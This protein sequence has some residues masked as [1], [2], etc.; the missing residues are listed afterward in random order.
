VRRR[1][2]WD[3]DTTRASAARTFDEYAEAFRDRF[4]TAVRRRARSA[5]PVGVSVSGGLDSSA[6]FCQ[7]DALR[8]ADP[9]LF[10]E[11]VG[12]SYVD[13]GGAA[14][15]RHYLEIVE[16]A[17]RQSIV[18]LP[19]GDH[20]GLVDTAR[21]QLWHVETPS[22]DYLWRATVA[23][24]QALRT[25]GARVL[26][27]GH[28]GDQML[29]STGYLVDLAR[30]LSW[31]QLG[32][33]LV[34]YRR[35]LGAGEAAVYARRLLPEIARS[36]VPA[37]LRA[38]LKRLR[39]RWL[40][41]APRGWYADTFVDRARRGADAL[42]ALDRRCHSEQARRLYLEARSAY[43]V[44]CMEWNNKA[45]AMDGQD[46]AFPFLDRDLVSLLIAMPGTMQNH[47]GVPRA[48]LREAMRGVLPDAVRAR[49]W[50]ADFSDAVNAG[51]GREHATIASLLTRDAH[52]VRRGFF[53]AD[54][55]EP[56]VARVAAAGIGDDCRDSWD[57]ADAFGFELWLRVFF[58]QHEPPGQA[59]PRADHRVA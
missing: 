33:H 8:R 51:V 57:L 31:I 43:H 19:L 32:R 46:H 44:Q 59:G 45:A 13:V 6:I 3:F 50:K 18:R 23:I 5:F 29:F 34:E 15:E 49:T 24:G 41:R 21:S 14:D 9:A 52:A 2:Y 37:A 55:L 20:L 28:W 12:V 11:L 35:W 1:K 42:V 26:L 10:P 22:L 54:R 56:A 17:C 7:A 47:G 48:V 30:R 53:D 16:Q 25:R 40:D 36:C 4:A 27:S 58:A 38:P 39:R